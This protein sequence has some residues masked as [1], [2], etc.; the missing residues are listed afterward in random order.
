MIDLW[1]HQERSLA[2]LRN[3]IS[4]GHRRPLL[5]IPTG[6]GKTRVAAAVIE[7]A[8]AKGNRVVFVVDAISLIDQTVEAFY[9][10]GLT[11]M[12]VIQADHIMTDWSRPIQVASV[13][14]L[15]RRDMPEATV[16]I[17][18]ECHVANQWLHK[19]IAADDWKNKIAIGLSATPWSKGLG[20]VYDDLISPVS[21]RELIDLGRLLDFRV[22]APCHP[23][24]KDVA[25]V[26]GDYNG[27]QLADTMSDSALV[28]DVVSTW[29]R[30][31]EG[32]PTLC[33]CVDR[34]H[35]KKVQ[36]RFLQAGVPA[37]YID[38]ATEAYERKQI[39]GRL[40]SGETKVVCNIATL[41]KG[42]DWKI[43]CI[44][45]A[46]PTK[47]KMLH[48][49]I[50]GRVIRANSG[51]PDGLVLDH[52]DNMLRLGL[53]TDIRDT[54]LCT[55]SKGERKK[56]KPDP[57]PKECGACGFLKPPKTRECPM[58]KHIPE[59]TSDIEEEEGELVQIGGAKRK[60]S[61]ADKQEWWSGLLSIQGSRGYKRGWASNKYREKFGVWPKGLADQAAQPSVEVTNFVRAGQIR[62]AKRRA[63]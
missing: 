47:S 44:I 42:I 4:A 32:R 51:F 25:T 16:A 57:L 26:A 38:M 52:S 14:T 41:T 53:P 21:M 35:A 7:G 43:G 58:C 28:A 39:K 27:A 12:G 37:E 11:E 30:L 50:A 59:V 62:F 40:E 15:Q 10:V 1:P 48:V 56:E 31:G 23:D 34:A 54:P 19:R 13:Q 55:L 24:L 17:I 45:I 29:L 63:A 5:K 49:Q 2:M 36:E 6:G 20:N 8:R 22:F 61:M 46:R 33:Y 18:D 60:F 3:S 9:E